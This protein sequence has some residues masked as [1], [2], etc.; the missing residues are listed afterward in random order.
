VS[1]LV[2]IT[3]AVVTY[4]E[5]R[6]IRDFMAHAVR[7]ADEV[8]VV[9]KSSD[10]GT[11][12]IAVGLGAKL[13]T[14]PFSPPGHMDVRAAVD[15]CANDWVWIFTAGEIPP[16]KLV[17]T[18]RQLLNQQ[19]DKLDIIAIPKKLYSF[20]IF[21]KRSPWSRGLQPFVINR[22]RAVI[23][24]KIHANFAGQGVAMDWSDDL[25]VLHATHPSLDAFLASHVPYLLKEAQ[26][27]DDPEERVRTAA[28]A[29]NDFDFGNPGMHDPLF[30]QMCAWRFYHYGVML[31]CWSKGWPAADPF[32]EELRA[33]RLKEWA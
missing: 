22:K 11:G 27:T 6:R 17:E 24:D 26:D 7:W 32:Y 14:I 29:M 1:N 13:L 3:A 31:A 18:V 30:G 20:G 9:D 10:D 28:Q 21:D 23:R 19:G 2:K 15:Q 16:R 8:L 5:A 12:E 33:E 4:N 25:A